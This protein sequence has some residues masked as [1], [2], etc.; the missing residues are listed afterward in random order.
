MSLG[1]ILSCTYFLQSGFQMRKVT[2]KPSSLCALLIT[3]AV[4]TAC[5]GGGGSTSSASPSAAPAPVAATPPTTQ[6]TTI[7]GTT[8]TPPIAT[9]PPPDTSG[10][11]QQPP[12]AGTG[13]TP[14]APIAPIAPLDTTTPL[15]TVT[16]D[17]TGAADQ[18]NVPVTFGQVFAVGHIGPSQTVTAML[19]AD[20]TSLPLQVDV[21]AR[22]PD[23]SVR[24]A[25]LTTTIPKV[26]I[27]QSHVIGLGVGPAPAAPAATSAMALIMEG[28]TASVNVTIDGQAYS[29]SAHHHLRAGAYETWLSGPL[30]NEWMVAAPLTNAAGVAHPHLAARFA[31]R[32]VTGEKRARVDVTVENNWAYELAPQNFKYDAQINVGETSVYSAVGMTHYHHSRWRKMF[33]WGEQPSVH[34]KHNV[35]YLIGTKA[36]PNYDQTVVVPET[37]LAAMATAFSGARIQP[38][39]VGSA[40]PAMPTTGGRDDIGLLPAWGATYLL[41]MDKRAKD[42]TLGTADLAGSWSSHYRDK[43]T[44][45]PVSLAD[46]PYMTILGNRTDTMNPVTKKLEAFPLC[47]TTTSCT[48]PNNHDT[49]HQPNFAYLPYLVTGDYYYLEELQFWAMFNSFSSNPGYR[50]NIKG[51]V[52]SDQ[53]RGQAW[54]LRTIG[55]AAYITPDTDTL[56]PHLLNLVKHNLDY[57]NAT[58]TNNATANK[59]GVITNGYSVVYNNSTGLAPWMDDFFTSAIGHLNELGFTS[60]RPLLE[61]KARFP[62]GRMI[63]PGTCWITGAMYSM[64]VRDSATAPLYTTVGEAWKASSTPEFAALACASQAMA[65]S[66]GLKVGEMTGY[67]AVATGYPSNMQPALAYAA[68][69]GGTPGASAWTVFAARSVKP[70]YGL[71]PQFAIVPR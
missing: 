22:H 43:N 1:I 47:A 52:R 68:D 50:E 23:G 3:S 66:L 38:M 62:I 32:A 11:V 55:E 19:M 28:F 57:F 29:A 21:K 40:L 45:R 53:V 16:V 60:A 37:R 39:G 69:V 46:Y 10:T 70:N 15:T 26:A 59:L 4:L 36:L 44:G 58:Y 42:I 51:L 49:S 54:S 24:H 18:L 41:T 13:I 31:I 2:I 33:W 12:L 56:K 61:W 14:T 48:T 30:V 5:G 27:R 7:T 17:S 6:T 25:V 67:S 34:V 71:G 20:N 8:T 65:T 64:K 35:A 63:D 9:L